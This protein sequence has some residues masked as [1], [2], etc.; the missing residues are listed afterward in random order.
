MSPEKRTALREPLYAKML[1]VEDDIPGYV[2]NISSVGF[3]VE[4][5]LPFNPRNGAVYTV[6][7]IPIDIEGCSEFSLT[8][9]V[10]WVAPGSVFTALGLAV[11]S[12]P[13]QYT[14]CF[15][16][17]L[18]FYNDQSSSAGNTSVFSLDP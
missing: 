2:R 1:F 10:R 6:K 14:A 4:T 15:R 9:E 3:K 7:V 18:D 12:I 11:K 16:T 5:L 13:K 17:L 8:M